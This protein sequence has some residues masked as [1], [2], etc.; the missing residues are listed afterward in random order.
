MFQPLLQIVLKAFI[1]R[2]VTRKQEHDFT[3][4]C[5]AFIDDPTVSV[6]TLRTHSFQKSVVFSSMNSVLFYHPGGVKDTS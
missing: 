4:T 3:N 2:G 1:H 5:F 6:A